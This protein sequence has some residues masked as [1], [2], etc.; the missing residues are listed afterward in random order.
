VNRAITAPVVRVT[1][2]G[3]ALGIMP[4]REAQ[5]KAMDAGLD[6]VEIAPH[7]APPV[8]DIR[9]YGRWRFEQS[10]AKKQQIKNQT[11]VK[12]KEI[13]VRPVIGQHD[14][15]TKI[16]SLKK[17]IAEGRSVQV[18]CVFSKREIMFKDQ[19]FQVIANITEAVK[20]VATPESPPKFNE[21]RLQVRFRPVKGGD[22]AK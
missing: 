13:Q 9:D 4:L 22:G 5:Q 21:K 19:G 15:G 12:M 3:Q 18:T 11:H 1:M 20:D 2:D 8:C 14:L 16:A 10:K 17:F 7:A 6:L